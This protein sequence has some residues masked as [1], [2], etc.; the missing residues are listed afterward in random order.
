MNITKAQRIA[1]YPA[2]AIRDFLKRQGSLYFSLHAATER[3]QIS[4]AEADRLMKQL[5]KLG[6]IRKRGKQ[7]T[8]YRTT[9]KGNAL[10]GASA[11]KLL[12]R[13]SAE[14]RLS[15]FMARV[16]EVNESQPFVFKVDTVVLFGSFL[17]EKERIGD[18]DLAVELKPKTE[19][20]AEFKSMRDARINTAIAAGQR[21]SSFLDRMM[22][23][24][25][26]VY[27]FLKSRARAISLHDLN[28]ISGMATARY[29]V[30]HGDAERVAALVAS[31]STEE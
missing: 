16:R 9:V 18:I 29:R 13:K 12:S 10:A 22:W 19:G 17:S 6:F 14:K 28:D 1:G 5:E 26:E 23:P 11:A 25:T 2:L 24:T 4:E 15:E 27:R 7:D 31:A 20:S 8:W 3:L 30:L 21:F